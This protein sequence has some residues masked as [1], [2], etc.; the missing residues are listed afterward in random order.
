[1]SPM[2]AA[3][4]SPVT[5]GMTLWKDR[6]PA[7]MRVPGIYAGR[8]EEPGDPVETVSRLAAH[9]VQFVQ[10]DDAVDL[11]DADGAA[12][13]AAL[14]VIRELTGHG[15]AA[16]WTLRMPAAHPAELAA[17]RL[18]SHLYPPASVLAGSAGDRIAAEWRN[19][20]HL[21]KCGY[22]L[23]PG[24]LEI[25]DRRMDSFRRLLIRNPGGERVIAPLLHGVPAGALPEPMLA[26]YLRADLLH[27]VGR[28]VWWT[29]YRIRRWPLTTTIP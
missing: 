16:E 20:F 27:Q 10:L 4:L 1:M 26:R 15:I 2:S 5:V 19:S 13:V 24:F 9:G 6:D 21:A 25:R 18:L 11:D 23:G 22:R 12:T 3:P 29:P 14:V 28:F 17:W 7:A 8:V